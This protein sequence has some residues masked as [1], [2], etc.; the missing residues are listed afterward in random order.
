MESREQSAS[1]RTALLAGWL[2]ILAGAF[3]IV[4][5]LALLAFHLVWM[6]VPL[7]MN[8]STGSLPLGALLTFGVIVLAC[9]LLAGG[10]MLLRRRSAGRWIVVGISAVA[11]TA[12][13]V[14]I[15]RGPLSLSELGWLLV[16]TTIV[17]LA[18][19]PST[20]QWL[21]HRDSDPG[22]YPQQPHYP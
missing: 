16:P 5:G 4:S 17:M 1:S 13:V 14:G 2:S 20:R 21:Q 19:A 18:L 3:L 9:T 7:A 15:V 22:Q 8:E 12:N 11:V 6:L 10:V